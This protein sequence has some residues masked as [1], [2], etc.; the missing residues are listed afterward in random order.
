VFH[1]GA[2]FEEAKATPAPR[3]VATPRVAA[4]GPAH[5]PAPAA[6][7]PQKPAVAPA[8]AGAAKP[9]PARRP[10]NGSAADSA[11]REF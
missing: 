3:A 9:A 11:W 10:T 6:S 8:Q 4:E 1:L 7:R 5:K 2:A